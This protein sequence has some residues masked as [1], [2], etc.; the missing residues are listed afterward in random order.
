MSGPLHFL[1]LSTVPGLQDDLYYLELNDKR[2]VLKERDF[3]E[4]AGILPEERSYVED[5]T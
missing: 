5:G 1:Y 2:G 4:K 3:Y